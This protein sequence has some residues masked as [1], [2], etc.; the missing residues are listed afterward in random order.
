MDTEDANFQQDMPVYKRR[1]D[2][3]EESTARTEREFRSNKLADLL[4]VSRSA[5]SLQNS[6][7][8]NRKAGAN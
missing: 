3:R 1:N 8:F 2:K 4:V 7:G 6:V 5:K